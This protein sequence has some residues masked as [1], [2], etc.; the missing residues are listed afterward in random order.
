MAGISKARKT[1]SRQ[2][3]KDTVTVAADN[4]KLET[5]TP[6]VDDGPKVRPNSIRKSRG[7]LSTSSGN[8][9][10]TTVNSKNSRANSI[11]AIEAQGMVTRQLLAELESTIIASPK[12]V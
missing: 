10:H 6:D 7:R 5:D 8:A 1:R 11:S 2:S 12:K 4:P 9:K 3:I